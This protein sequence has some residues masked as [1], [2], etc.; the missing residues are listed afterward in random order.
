MAEKL[1]FARPIVANPLISKMKIAI[2]IPTYNRRYLVEMH[3]Q[4]LCSARL[5]ANTKIIVIDDCSADF[6]VGYLKTIY[7]EN[8][9]IRRRS[10][11]SGGADFAAR[12]LMVQLAE[13]GADVFVLLDSDMIVASDFLE[14]GMKLL[15]DCDGVLS[16]F[17]TPNHPAIG[18]RGPLVLKKTVGSTA[19][20][21]RREIAIEMLLHVAPGPSFDLRFS[22]F[23]INAGYQICTTKNSYAQHAGFFEGQNHRFDGRGDFGIGF[24]DTDVRNAYRLIEIIVHYMQSGFSDNAMLSRFSDNAMLSRRMNRVEFLLGLTLLRRIKRWLK[25]RFV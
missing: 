12:D 13:T 2:G 25:E 8:A 6:D 7:P 11:N 23:L 16:L 9:D 21:W 17:N 24:S 19:T 20:I 4:S 22:E 5:P 18:F 15:S 1:P 3:A 14:V 10:E